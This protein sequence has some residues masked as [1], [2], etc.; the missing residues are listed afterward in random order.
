MQTSHW[1][2]QGLHHLPKKQ[3]V[4]H[5]HKQSLPWSSALHR[6][7][8]VIGSNPAPGVNGVPSYQLLMAGFLLTPPILLRGAS[9][10]HAPPILHHGPLVF[11]DQGVMC[12]ASSSHRHPAG[13]PPHTCPSLFSNLFLLLILLRLKGVSPGKSLSVFHPSLP[14]VWE[15]NTNQNQGRTM[16]MW[17]W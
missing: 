1:S 6:A 14:S 13:I 4:F 10:C 15:L 7:S 11:S 8:P 16:W 17:R 5:S 9:L 2:S 12:R 3:H